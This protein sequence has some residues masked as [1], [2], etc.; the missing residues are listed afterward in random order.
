MNKCDLAK[1]QHMVREKLKELMKTPENW[2]EDEHGNFSCF[3]FYISIQMYSYNLYIQGPDEDVLFDTFGT[4][5]CTGSMHEDAFPDWI[6]FYYEVKN[7]RSAQRHCEKLLKAL[8][9]ASGSI[10]YTEDYLK[11]NDYYTK[12]DKPWWKIW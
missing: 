3:P 1:T 11:Q 2:K 12:V 7:E 10:V 6:K 5:A 8:N 9:A 4:K